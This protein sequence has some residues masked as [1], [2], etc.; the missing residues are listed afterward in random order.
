[1]D[2]DAAQALAYQL[3]LEEQH[4]LEQLEKEYAQYLNGSTEEIFY[5]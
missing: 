1:M 3:E 2:D 4:E 5:V